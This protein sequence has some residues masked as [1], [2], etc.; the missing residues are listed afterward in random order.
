MRYMWT[1][2]PTILHETG[3][4]VAKIVS[5]EPAPALKEV[6][7]HSETGTIIALLFYNVSYE[8]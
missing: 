2:V 3:K 4:P 7:E 8:S 6:G 1:T 5:R